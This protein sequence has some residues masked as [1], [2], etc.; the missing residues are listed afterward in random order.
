MTLAEVVRAYLLSLA[1]VTALVNARIWE[2]QMP[3][4][5]T[6]PAV[7]I[8]QISEVQAPHLRGTDALVW[9]RVQIDCVAAT[10]KA[11]RA[12]DQA[13]LGDYVGGVVTGLRG[14]TATLGS[15]AVELVQALADGYR[16][17]FDRDETHR[18]RVSRDYRVWMM[19]A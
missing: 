13:I 7:L 10:I 2:V 15:P 5:P 17:L 12:V 14:A 11:A 6:L 16:E 19:Q 3:Q 8:Q 1:P 18:A 4:N 9:G